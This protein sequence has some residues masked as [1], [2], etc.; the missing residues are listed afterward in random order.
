MSNS[1]DIDRLFREKFKDFETAVPKNTWKNISPQIHSQENSFVLKS[2]TYKFKYYI[3]A[4]LIVIG[5]AVG[6]YVNSQIN[7]RAILENL[8]YTPTQIQNNTDY[9]VINIKQFKENYEIN[10]DLLKQQVNYKN[11]NQSSEPVIVTK[12]ITS[13]TN[14]TTENVTN[15]KK[16]N[17]FKAN[18]FRTDLNSDVLK[19]KTT[20]LT[21][22][23]IE[24]YINSVIDTTNTMIIDW[25]EK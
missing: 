19:I 25:S 20:T 14:Y 15:Y 1:K 17:Y 21:E 6:L 5:S 18:I 11:N 16:E 2:N 24:N 9:E 4:C 13:N 7:E 3:S 12:N 10:K 23:E 8:V 22:S